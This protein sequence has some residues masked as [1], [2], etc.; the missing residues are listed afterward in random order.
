MIYVSLSRGKG[1]DRSSPGVMSA[2]TPVPPE[3]SGPHEPDG[4]HEISGQLQIS[5]PS[6]TVRPSET[7][8]IRPLDV[9]LSRGRKRQAREGTSAG[10]TAALAGRPDPRER[11]QASPGKSLPWRLQPSAEGSY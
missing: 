7:G 11:V 8:S 4:P 6:E 1:Q 2:R 3:A 5:E 9:R 10:P